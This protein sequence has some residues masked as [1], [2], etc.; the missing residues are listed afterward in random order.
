M[1]RENHRSRQASS[2]EPQRPNASMRADW[3]EPGE[4]KPEF[5]QQRKYMYIAGLC[6]P[7]QHCDK[8][9][10]KKNQETEHYCDYKNR[11]ESNERSESV[12]V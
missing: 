11:R 9:K 2:V 7:K 12:C 6:N 4:N 10:R 3:G 1:K 5:N 8:N